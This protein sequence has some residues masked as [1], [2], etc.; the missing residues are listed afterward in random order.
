[1]DG[2]RLYLR[3]M[4][5]PF[6][7]A[8]GMSVMVGAAC[9]WHFGA[10]RDYVAL[11]VSLVGVIALQAGANLANDYYDH[12]SRNDEVNRW[13]GPFSGGSR[14]IQDGLLPAKS[15]LAAAG[16]AFAIAMCA[17]GYL[18]ATRGGWP[19]PVL[20]LAGLVIG[21]LYTADPVRL[22]YHG[23]GE[24]AI[25]VAFGPLTTMGAYYVQA[26]RI[27]EAAFWS[28]VPPGLLVALILIVNEFPDFEADSSVA[29]N[30]LI[31]LLGL[32][33]GVALVA[34]VYVLAYATV[35]WMVASGL[36]PAPALLALATLP[37]ALFVAVRLRRCRLVPPR[38]Q[39]S[40][41]A[42]VATHLA[43][44]LILAVA[45]WVG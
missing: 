12:L 39:A 21:F 15:M 32:E 9:A 34:A 22:A 18:L 43:F 30:N 28:G 31:V 5:A 25:F 42:H 38:L 26:G 37:A 7:T 45:Y 1:M 19:I 40:S 8:S 6:F 4:R 36:A 44:C 17:M 23:L 35:A 20:A 29:K 16:A 33:R 3:A 27:D 24:A 2:V 14:V 11:A 10:P 13:Y 41:A